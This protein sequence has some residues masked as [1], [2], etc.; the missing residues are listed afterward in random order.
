MDTITFSFILKCSDFLTFFQNTWWHRQ[1]A[2][3]LSRMP[4]FPLLGIWF[5]DLCWEQPIYV[6]ARL[7]DI[8]FYSS[9]KQPW[10]TASA[11]LVWIC[12]DWFLMNKYF[13]RIN[14]DLDILVDLRVLATVFLC[15]VEALPRSGLRSGGKPGARSP[16]TRSSSFGTSRLSL[17]CISCLIHVFLARLWQISSLHWPSL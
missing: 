14:H 16:R 6:R 7:R 5:H 4:Q 3:H 1:L 15:A 17:F 12:K 2:T 11:N 13:W 8:L 10:W 9:T